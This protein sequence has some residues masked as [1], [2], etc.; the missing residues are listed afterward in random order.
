MDYVFAFDLDMNLINEDSKEHKYITIKPTTN[1]FYDQHLIELY[2][3]LEPLEI[4]EVCE[5]VFSYSLKLNIRKTLE[6]LNIMFSPNLQSN[7]NKD[8]QYVFCYDHEMNEIEEDF[9]HLKHIKIKP[10][11][12]FNYENYLYELHPLLESFKITEIIETTFEFHD[13]FNIKE[14][15]ESIGIKYSDELQQH[16]GKT[17]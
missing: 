3:L 17:S 5:T 12:N 7:I 13:D 14:F 11:E 4:K 1:L 6:N 9:P 2:S 15:M 10:I 16:I 8:W